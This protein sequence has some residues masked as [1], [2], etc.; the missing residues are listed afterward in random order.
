[1][2]VRAGKAHLERFGSALG[3]CFDFGFGGGARFMVAGGDNLLLMKKKIIA[4][5][6]AYGACFQKRERHTL[7][8]AS[9]F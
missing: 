2:P 6:D 3:N 7:H 9:C 8:W 1:M 4:A 5:K